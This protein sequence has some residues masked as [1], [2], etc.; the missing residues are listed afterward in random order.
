MWIC[1]SGAAW[2]VVSC[3]GPERPQP[4][5]VFHGA[6]KGWGW[7]AGRIGKDWDTESSIDLSIC[8]SSQ[9]ILCMKIHHNALNGK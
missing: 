6:G 4:Q 3:A 9:R 2:P 5:K 8:M 1:F 7:G